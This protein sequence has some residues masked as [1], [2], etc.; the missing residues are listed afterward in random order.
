MSYSTAQDERIRAHLAQA[1][2]ASMLAK[3]HNVDAMGGNFWDDIKNSSIVKT[4]SGVAKT[5]LPFVAPGYGTAISAGLGAVGL[6]LKKTKVLE[7]VPDLGEP[8]AVA[9]KKTRGRPTNKK[10]E[11]RQEVAEVVAEAIPELM[12]VL[13]VAKKGRGRPKGSK[14][15]VGGS[16]YDQYMKG[17]A[18][19]SVDG[20][21]GGNMKKKRGEMVRK[22][23][24]ENPGHTMPEASTAV[25]EMMRTI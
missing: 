5:I 25:A 19:V 7:A 21:T 23:M 8:L 14:K 4:L 18:L 10:V 15:V 1:L 20:P 13:K 6:G 2:K 22:W 16:A 17:G 3:G 12:A 9:A 24:K 11:A